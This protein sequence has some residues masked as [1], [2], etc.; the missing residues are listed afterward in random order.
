MDVITCVHD[1]KTYNSHLNWVGVRG[2]S[3]IVTEGGGL[4]LF[5]KG[6]LSEGGGA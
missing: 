1:V 3:Y 2:G 6:F 5:L 4:F